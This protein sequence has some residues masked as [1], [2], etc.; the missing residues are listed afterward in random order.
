MSRISY[1]DFLRMVAALA[2]VYQHVIEQSDL[3]FLHPSL[4]L[5]PGVFGVALF[6]FIS[7]YV[8]PYSV[9]TWSGFG[10]FAIRR[11]FRIVPAYYATLALILALSLLTPGMWPEVA[12]ATLKDWGANLVLAQ[13]LTRSPTILGVAWTLVIEIAWYG[14]FVLHFLVFRG[15]RV[16]ETSILLS[17]GIVALSVLSIVVDQRLPF[18]RIGLLHAAFAGYCAYKHHEGQIS[19]GT[20]L[21]V[22]A[23]F[24][25]SMI[26]SQIVSFGYFTHPTISLF[27]GACGW[28]GAALVFFIYSLSRTLRDAPFSNWRP[29]VKLGEIS[30]SVYLVHGVVLG[31]HLYFIGEQFVWLTVIPVTLLLSLGMFAWIEKPGI[32]L[33]RALTQR[34]VSVQRGS[35]A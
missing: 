35:S 17:V 28:G 5:A 8:I 12:D 22:C 33:G 2:V 23:G 4:Q 18:G 31:V 13:D 25:I 19:Q 32:E 15:R 6:F 26:I 10:A 7:G 34:Y 21:W 27:N 9:R 24:L 1:I 11:V 30:Y 20:Y 29:F 3:L 16:V 14:L